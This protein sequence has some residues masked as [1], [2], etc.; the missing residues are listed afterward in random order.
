MSKRDVLPVLAAQVPI[1]AL[2]EEN[3]ETIREAMREAAARGAEVVLFPETALT[4]YA[5]NI[6]RGRRPAEWPAI[7]QALAA[8]AELAR[9][10]KLWTIVGSEAWDGQSWWNRL[11]V[12]SEEGQL[13]ATYDKVHLTA[14]DTRYYQSGKRWVLFELKGIRAGLQICYDVRFPDGY[15]ALLDRGVEVIFQGFYGAGKDTWKVPVMGAHLRSRAAECGCFLVAANVAG[16]LQIVVSQI[17]DPMGLILAQANQDRSELIQAELKLERIAESFVREDY[18]QR[19]Q[20][21]HAQ[22]KNA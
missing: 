15:R 14:D 12:Y 4:G 5:P 16:P 17:V 19:F 9:E 3:L 7:A 2:L 8:I 18:F 11:Y 13:A 10:L 6:G 21:L 22:V 20:A 1:G